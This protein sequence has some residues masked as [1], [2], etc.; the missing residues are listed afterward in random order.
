MRQVYEFL[1][2]QDLLD[3]REA[4]FVRV[5]DSNRADDDA[6]KYRKDGV[7][8]ETHPPVLKHRAIRIQQVRIS[9][10][11]LSSS[12]FP[13]RFLED[14]T[15]LSTR[16][17]HGSQS[18]RRS[19]YWPHEYEGRRMVLDKSSKSLVKNFGFLQIDTGTNWQSFRLAP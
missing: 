8:P 1:A 2:R 10:D 14:F 4:G 15:R 12:P 19:S 17:Y 13:G 11:N 9:R 16:L 3:A 18:G 5:Y 7:A 6:Q